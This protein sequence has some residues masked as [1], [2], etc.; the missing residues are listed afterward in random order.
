MQLALGAGAP[1]VRDHR[2]P[3]AFNLERCAA[4]GAPPANVRVRTPRSETTKTYPTTTRGTRA[5]ARA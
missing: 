4:P 5:G 1:N 2:E 3:D